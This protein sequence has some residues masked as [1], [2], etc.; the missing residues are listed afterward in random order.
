MMNKTSGARP[1]VATFCVGN[2]AFALFDR[3][4]IDTFG[5]D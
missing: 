3:Y 4:D 1:A 2:R 5:I